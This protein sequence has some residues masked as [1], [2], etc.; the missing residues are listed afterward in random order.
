MDDRCGRLCLDFDKG[1]RLR[2]ALLGA[3][4][5][6]AAADRGRAVGDPTRLT[7]AAVLNDGGELCVC[8]LAWVTGRSMKLVSHHLGVLRAAGLAT[9][10]RDGKVVFY[11]LTV[12]GRR[13]LEASLEPAAVGS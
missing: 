5:A 12:P 1:E 7:I 6:R 2:S 11:S 9:S 13:V 10:R 8:D 4:V 3:E